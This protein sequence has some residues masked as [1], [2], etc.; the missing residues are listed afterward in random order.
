MG[1]KFMGRSTQNTWRNLNPE[2]AMPPSSN[3]PG[4]VQSVTET[5]T[6]VQVPLISG[7]EA[8]EFAMSGEKIGIAPP[9]M[10]CIGAP[11]T[12]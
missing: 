5:V 6:E 11:G 8:R 12:A 10:S 1:A 2:H 9:D 3:H 4:R 7:R